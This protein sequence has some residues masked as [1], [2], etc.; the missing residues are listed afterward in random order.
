MME[1]TKPKLGITRHSFQKWGKIGG[2]ITGEINKKKG[3]GYFKKLSKLAHEAKR[4]KTGIK[5]LDSAVDI[6]S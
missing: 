2:K 5:Y 4:K 1:K 6:M 3:K